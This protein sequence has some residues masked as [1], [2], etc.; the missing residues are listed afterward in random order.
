MPVF[1]QVEY[2]RLLIVK[3]QKTS[4][5]F[6]Q[7]ANNWLDEFKTLAKYDGFQGIALEVAKTELE[8]AKKANLG[9]KDRLTQD[10]LRLLAAMTHVRQRVPG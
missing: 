5:E 4:L 10:A 3:K 7:E 1:A 8:L 2:F 9:E 6:L